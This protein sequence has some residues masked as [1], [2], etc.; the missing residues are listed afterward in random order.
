MI[1][2]FLL[3]PF[4]LASVPS[5]PICAAPGIDQAILNAKAERL[6]QII[7]DF[8]PLESC[9]A[10][11]W[12]PSGSQH[13]DARLA[14]VFNLVTNGGFENGIFGPGWCV[15]LFCFF[16]SSCLVQR[17][18]FGNTGGTGLACGPFAS[19][20]PTEGSCQAFFGPI[21]STGG[22]QQS[23]STVPGQSYTFSYDLAVLDSGGSVTP[24]SFRAEFGGT[25]VESVT[26]AP[27][28]PYG[29]RSFTV[30]AIAAT[31]VVT[32]TFQHDPSYFLL[33]NVVVSPLIQPTE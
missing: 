4:C 12:N 15:L 28:S 10:R 25:V 13:V 6:R 24:N 5:I 7:G 21:G 33:D 32:F 23:I 3:L 30:T 20:N 26:N 27:A 22:I 11:F 2:L 1:I 16:F 19:R 29:T 18:Q 9:D 8:I 31:T 14:P 17:I